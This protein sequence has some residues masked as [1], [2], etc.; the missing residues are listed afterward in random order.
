MFC[1]R[2][3]ISAATI[4]V[5][6]DLA[7]ARFV[8][9]AI[10]NPNASAI[11]LRLTTVNENWNDADAAITPA[12]LNPL[13]QMA[14][15]RSSCTRF[16]PART[17]FRGSMVLQGATAGQTFVVVALVQNGPLITA[18]PVIPEKAPNVP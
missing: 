18:V 10:A 16:L 3:L 2:N 13:Q 9:F 17:T 7:A 11:S 8:G 4:P 1:R 15:S 12:E 6:N 14:R 5:Y